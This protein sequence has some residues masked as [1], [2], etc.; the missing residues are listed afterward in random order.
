MIRPIPTLRGWAVGLCGVVSLVASAWLG[1]VDLLFVGLL[2]TLAPFAA[3][4]AIALDRPLLT[5]IRSFAPDTVPVGEGAQVRLHVRNEAVRPTPGFSWVDTLPADVAQVPSRSFPSLAAATGTGVSRG[6][7]TAT[8]RYTA[9]PRRRGAYLLGPVRVFRTDPFGLAR[10]GYAVGESKVLLVTPRIVELGRGGADEARG[11]GDDPELVRHAIPSAD[12]VIPRDY[13]AGDPL[14]RVQWRAT[15]RTGRLMVRQ[16]EQRS[17]PESAVLLDTM[18]TRSAAPEVFDR[19]VELVASLGS[20]L[21]ELGYLVDLHE[22]G[23][24]QVAGGYQLPGGDALMIGRLAGVQQT[25]EPDG[26]FVGRLSIALRAGHRACPLF[27]VL[28]D[29]DS[30]SWRGLAPL[31]GFAEPAVAFLMT[32]AARAAQPWLDEAGWVCVAVEESMDAAAAWARAAESRGSRT[33]A[34]PSGGRRV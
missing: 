10:C 26:D 25:R 34:A 3:M 16:E 19:A 8:L 2:L 29:G 28:V 5:V 14:R 18:T 17:S 15:A 27:L 24:A 22:T 6:A 4:V 13:R 7:E 1:R 31:S 32:P 21:L 30:A 11:E 9:R 33:H 20:H 23:E 12:E